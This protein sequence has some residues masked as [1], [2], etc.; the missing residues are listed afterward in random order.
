[1]RHLTLEGIHETI[2]LKQRRA[3][4][5]AAAAA[6][7]AAADAA[8]GGPVRD[9]YH[10]P[11]N[12]ST[13]EFFRAA[14]LGEDKVSIV[15]APPPYVAAADEERGGPVFP[16]RIDIPYQ[17]NQQEP[18]PAEGRGSF[19]KDVVRKPGAEGDPEAVTGDGDRETVSS[20]EVDEEGV[21]DVSAKG[22]PMMGFY[23]FLFFRVVQGICPMLLGALFG[24][25][26]RPHVLL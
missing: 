2:R 19:Q 20:S 6:A 26:Y 5:A 10:L 13:E 1:M 23:L 16:R 11:K 24:V 17:G 21:S 14:S 3:K 4:S 9:R 12:L 25:L 22:R 7:A 15:K 8:T 18:C